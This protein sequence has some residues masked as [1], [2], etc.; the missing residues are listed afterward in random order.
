MKGIPL[1]D[2][3][4]VKPDKEEEKVGSIIIGKDAASRPLRGTV[5]A[6]G[7]GRTLETGT[8]IPMSLRP[9]DTVMFGK[10]SGSEI[11]LGQEDY[12]VMSEPDVLMKLVD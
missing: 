6:V 1:S 2:R 4:L 7:P 8:L 3:I 10:F 12:L 5:V 9:G 11:R